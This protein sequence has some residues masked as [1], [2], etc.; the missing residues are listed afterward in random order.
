MPGKINKMGFNEEQI[1]Q[2]AAWRLGYG[3]AEIKYRSIIS[4]IKKALKQP[5]QVKIT[6][7]GQEIIS[8]DHIIKQIEKILKNDTPR[9]NRKVE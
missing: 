7:K 1:I 3:E 8:S 9:K 5:K 6:T 2:N 4:K